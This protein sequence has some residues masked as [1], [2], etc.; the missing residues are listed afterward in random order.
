MI[1]V[2]DLVTLSCGALMDTVSVVSGN[3]DAL[4]VAAQ[5]KIG[6]AE[7]SHSHVVLRK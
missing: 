3:Q 5:A 6:I 2:A 1:S 4:L 7:P